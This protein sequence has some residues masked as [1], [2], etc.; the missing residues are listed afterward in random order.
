MTPAALFRPYWRTLSQLVIKNFQA[1]P[2]MA[3]QLCDLLG[4]EIN[5]FLR[6]TTSYTLPY[7]V[8]TRKKDIISRIAM[9]HS[10]KSISELI[11]TRSHL[12]SILALLLVQPLPNPEA[13]I[14][15]ILQELSVKF[16]DPTLSKLVRS[17]CV[18]I[19][20]ELLRGLGSSGEGK[21]S[22]VMHFTNI[23]HENT[24]T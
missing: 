6:L 14:P 11:K 18:P 16:N 2:Q 5:G 22:K 10:K 20:C 13:A 21:G 19:T 1:R 7:L 24:N 4:M 9:T 15:C 23:I 8:L 12:A 3:D 17:E